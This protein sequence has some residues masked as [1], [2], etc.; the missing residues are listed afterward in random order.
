[1]G[2]DIHLFAE[3]IVSKPRWFEFWKKPKW[4]TIDKYTKNPDFGRFPNEQEYIIDDEDR[5]YR[6]RNYN[7]FC[8]LAGVR[9]FEFSNKPPIVSKPKGVPKDCCEEIKRESASYGSDGHS[10]TW[11]TLAELEAFD[12][13]EYGNTCDRFKEMVFPKL[14]EACS[15]P[16]DVRIVY[17][18]DN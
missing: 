9:S 5:I 18:F 11:N 16:N 2:C 12:W 7:L 3:K 4:A 8:A 17:F 6:G 15:D 13:S 10:H 1:M 14:R